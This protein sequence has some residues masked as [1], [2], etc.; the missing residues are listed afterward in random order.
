MMRNR[1]NPL[2]IRKK[3]KIKRKMKM[4]KIQMLK[5]WLFLCKITKKTRQ[6]CWNLENFMKS[7]TSGHFG[8]FILY[9]IMRRRNKASEDVITI[10][11]CTKYIALKQWKIFGVCTIIYIP[12]KKLCLIPIICFLEKG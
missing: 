6:M 7:N 12:S 2:K 8:M 10:I 9:R 1:M 3:M 11:F 5:R 4:Y